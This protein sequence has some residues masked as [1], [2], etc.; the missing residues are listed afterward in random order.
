MSWRIDS[1]ALERAREV[2]RRHA[3]ETP[4]V[5]APLLG[6]G[7]YLKLETEQETGSFKLRGA[8]AALGRARDCA[9]QPT[10]G[11]W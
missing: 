6:E 8:L 9:R 5:L 11:G 10:R 4:L 3:R 2:V 1:S 7:A